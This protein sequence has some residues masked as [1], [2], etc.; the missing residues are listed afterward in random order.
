MF[1]LSYFFSMLF[2]L[3]FSVSS[4]SFSGGKGTKDEPYQITHCAELQ[5]ISRYLEAHFELLNDINCANFDYGDNKGFMPL[6]VVGYPFTGTLEGHDFTILNLYIDRKDQDQVGLFGYM[7]LE[8]AVQNLRVVSA[9]IMGG[10]NTGGIVGYATSATGVG[11]LSN[12]YFEGEVSGNTYVGGLA[13]HSSYKPIINSHVNATVIATGDNVG[14]LAGNIYHAQI[15]HSSAAGKVSTTDPMGSHVGGLVGHLAGSYP[16]FEKNFANNSVLGYQNVGGLIG[17]A[18]YAN[19]S[20]S[21]TQGD[22]HAYQVV[23]G[24]I[25]NHI[26]GI[27]MNSYAATRVIGTRD[28]GGLIGLAE[29]TVIN[30]YWDVIISGQSDSAGGTPKNTTE[31]FLTDTYVNWDFDNIWNIDEGWSYPYLQ[32]GK[33]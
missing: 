21:Y 23:G 27:V 30:S 25:G 11:A 28:V 4:F 26:F 17:K 16:L 31:M 3:L 24:L 18:L 10:N 2:F 13:G 6:G 22:V 33:I 14:G 5:N 29:G 19:I 15:S 8:S 20:D 1:R 12:L 7:A 9:V 32:P